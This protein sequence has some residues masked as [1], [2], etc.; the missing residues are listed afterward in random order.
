M[1]IKR[2]HSN[3]DENPSGARTSLRKLIAL[4]M[5]SLVASLS[6][7]QVT[8]VAAVTPTVWSPWAAGGT[9]DVSTTPW[10]VYR[11]VVATNDGTGIG[12]NDY[13]TFP[14]IV[15]DRIHRRLVADWQTGYT[16]TQTNL[17][18]VVAECLDGRNWGNF[19]HL[20]NVVAQGTQFK[21]GILNNGDLMAACGR[22]HFTNGVPVYDP[23]Y[24][25]SSG[26]TFRT[27][28]TNGVAI[29]NTDDAMLTPG[30]PLQ[31]PN[32]NIL[33][34]WYSITNRARPTNGVCISTNFGADWTRITID[35]AGSEID[36]KTDG[37]DKLWALSRR[38]TSVEVYSSTNFGWA[39]NDEGTAN[40]NA[41]R[42]A[43]FA[44]FPA[45]VFSGQRMIVGFRD[46]PFGNSCFYYS[47]LPPYTNGW[48]GFGRNSNPSLYDSGVSIGA[49]VTYWIS[50]F[51]TAST[52]VKGALYSSN[53]WIEA[54]VTANDGLG[55]P[56]SSVD[57]PSQPVV[58]LKNSSIP[59][60]GRMTQWEN[61]GTGIISITNTSANGPISMPCSGNNISRMAWCAGYTNVHA[62]DAM[63]LSSIWQTGT[64]TII[65]QAGR[66]NLSDRGYIMDNCNEKANG[67]GFSLKRWGTS[68][69]F[70]I[71]NG[72]G[73]NADAWIQ[74]GDADVT[75]A[76]HIFAVSFAAEGVCNFFEDG[77]RLNGILASDSGNKKYSTAATSWGVLS[78]G[79][80]S[81]SSNVQCPTFLS[82]ILIFTNAL[83]D[84]EVYARMAQL[85]LNNTNG[86]GNPTTN[87]PPASVLQLQ[88]NWIYPPDASISNL[89]FAIRHSTNLALPIMQWSVLTNI[90]ASANPSLLVTT[91]PGQHYFAVTAP[92]LLNGSNSPGGSFS[93]PMLR[94]V[95]NM[96]NNH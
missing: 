41:S 94:G 71:N 24:L 5:L 18:P 39:W 57:F 19:Y 70:T 49:G 77:K 31:L 85:K 53:A 33:V 92:D 58:W 25:I 52:S 34:G 1:Q 84:S 11:S 14:N 3:N 47:D 37:N 65:W 79:T 23:I 21:L 38:A 22:R 81:S 45:F 28:R 20:T 56:W 40:F 27:W 69:R 26:D 29:S 13:R 60:S 96:P 16:H 73:T 6:P 87:P 64:G 67:V 61:W 35:S 48:T 82:D 4:L 36:F 54:W 68:I 17:V 83:A 10:V 86:I 66:T 50:A 63:A 78:F 59:V 89:T 15:Y 80:Y 93:Q 9:F 43:E 2:L 88:W 91:Q 51:D 7:A 76:P 74:N 46:Q 90:T 55:W 32:G 75:G 44:S 42:L 95:I 72:T 12:T 8:N 30:E 62:G